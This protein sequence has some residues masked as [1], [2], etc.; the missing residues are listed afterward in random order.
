MEKRGNFYTTDVDLPSIGMTYQVQLNTGRPL[1]YL[2]EPVML[3]AGFMLKSERDRYFAEFTD[4]ELATVEDL[5]HKLWGTGD[6]KEKK[7][8]SGQLEKLKNAV[9]KRAGIVD[10]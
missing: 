8:Y 6:F 3:V 4:E 2:K 9:Q 10:T 7:K 5:T 1:G